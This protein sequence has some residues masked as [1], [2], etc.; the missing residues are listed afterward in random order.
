MIKVSIIIPIYNVEAYLRQCLDSV[1][2]QTLK[3]IEIICVNDGSTDSSLNIIQEYA[4]KDNRIIVIDK[5][6]SGY[7]HS[8]N[9][10]IDASNGEYIGIVEPDDFV[11]LDMFEVLYNSAVSND[12]EIVKSDFYR[13]IEKDNNII[14][15]YIQLT[16]NQYFYNRVIIPKYEQEVFKFVMNTWTGLYKRQFLVSNN[17][18]HNE[19]PGA[20]FQDNGFWFQGFCLTKSLYLIDKSFYMNRR[21]NP[22]S[23]VKNKEKVYCANIEY[24][25]IREFLELHKLYDSFKSV[26]VMKLWHNCWFTYN[27]IDKKFKLKY[28]SDIRNELK[29]FYG[30]G[31]IDADHF[32]RNE[33]LAIQKIM[34]NPTLFY[35][36]YG[37]YNKIREIFR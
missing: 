2:N 19:T 8:M 9:V 13:F 20:S 4:S 22:N 6:N 24:K 18:R 23:S 32:S 10:G 12:V 30:E 29:S 31:L 17:I 34:K 5:K 15:T 16:K 7:G 36:E 3:E 21:D 33:L 11:A 28:I 35:I 25:Y 26:Y 1:I 14:R 37:I 27:R